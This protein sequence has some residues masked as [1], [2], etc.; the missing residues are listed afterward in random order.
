[1]PIHPRLTPDFNHWGPL[2]YLAAVLQQPGRVAANY[3][4]GRS[5]WRPRPVL[6]LVVLVA[7]TTITL[8]LL[9]RYHPVWS[10]LRQQTPLTPGQVAQLGGRV[11]FWGVFSN[12]RQLLLLPLYAL[13]TW[14]LYRREGAGYADALFMHVLWNTAYNLYSLVLF[15]L[16]AV[17]LQPVTQLGQ[18]LQVLLPP[19]YLLAVGYQGLSLSWP[20]AIAKALLTV[21]SMG[22]VLRLLDFVGL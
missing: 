4:A 12:L 20:M 22:L 5:Q 6:V 3:W 2:A 18:P 19:V 14:L 8:L 11:R 13:P 1:M 10:I 21:I 15:A 9:Q 16:M 17:Q 7:L